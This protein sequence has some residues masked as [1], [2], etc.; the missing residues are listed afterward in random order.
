MR[1]RL[2]RDGGP[3]EW[4]VVLE[5]PN[6]ERIAKRDYATRKAAEKARDRLAAEM[7]GETNG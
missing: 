7:R 5:G 4:A 2:I 6:G 3:R 1:L